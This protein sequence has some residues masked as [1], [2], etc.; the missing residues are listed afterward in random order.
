MYQDLQSKGYVLIPSFLSAEELQ[1]FKD[2]LASQEVLKDNE[3][4]DLKAIS[5]DPPIR[6]LK[7]K[8]DA[9][10][11]KVREFGIMVD[12]CTGGAYFS[13]QGGQEFKWHQDHESY[14]MFQEHYNYLNLYIPIVKPTKEKTN[15]AIFPFDIIKAHC[16]ELYDKLVGRGATAYIVH[17]GKTLVYNTEEDNK[18]G[19]FPF[20]LN[21]HA[22]IPQLEEGDLLLLRGDMIHATA[23]TDTV[24]CSASIRLVNGEGTIS[25]KKFFHGG[26]SKLNAII[27]NREAYNYYGTYMSKHRRD[28]FEVEELMTKRA[29]AMQG[30]KGAFKVK[31]SRSKLGFKMFM[32][33]N[34]YL[35]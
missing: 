35:S 19:E 27:N 8:I 20:D 23:D 15:L 24:R 9:L 7:P 13:T 25:K 5:N 16:P 17:D 2:D 10:M 22:V 21:D 32:L 3:N 12:T 11:D 33:I 29:E 14:Y 31:P 30:K 6:R 4:Y 1:L 26:K 18:L 28:E 34:R